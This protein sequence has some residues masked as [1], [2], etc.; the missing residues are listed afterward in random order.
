MSRAAQRGGDLS[1]DV[2][3][4]PNE[5]R[6]ELVYRVHGRSRPAPYDAAALDDLLR[7]IHDNVHIDALAQGRALHGALRA[8]A[9]NE[10]RAPS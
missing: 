4:H 6:H 7:Q 8:P 2:A 5:D 10:S 3:D 1:I 9:L